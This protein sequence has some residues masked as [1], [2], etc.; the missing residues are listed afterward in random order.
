MPHNSFHLGS[1]RQIC[2]EL[3]LPSFAL[4]LYLSVTIQQ[5]LVFLNV[6]EISSEIPMFDVATLSLGSGRINEDR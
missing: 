1:V 6:L 4:M 3:V 2:P 5:A